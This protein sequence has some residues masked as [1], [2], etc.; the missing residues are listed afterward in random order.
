MRLRVTNADG[1]DEQR[2]AP[3]AVV[4]PAPTPTPD[5][6]ADRRPP[7]PTSDADP[8]RRA[9]RVPTATPRPTPS[10]DPHR[11]AH[12]HRHADGPATDDRRH[13]VRVARAPP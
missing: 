6:D 11:D 13:R 5:A 2:S 12:E 8:D 1:F 3:T 7:L 4:A 10:A 9:D